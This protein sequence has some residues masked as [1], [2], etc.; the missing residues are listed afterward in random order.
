MMKRQMATKGRWSPS[1]GLGAVTFEDV[2][3][4]RLSG[5]TLRVRE[6][7]TDRWRKAAPA[8]LKLLPRDSAFTLDLFRAQRQLLFDL[9]LN[10]Q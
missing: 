9:D 8:Y 10:A 6:A 4:V 3:Q 7:Q 1:K 2:E 5:D